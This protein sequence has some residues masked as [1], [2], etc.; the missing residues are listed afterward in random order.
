MRKVALLVIIVLVLLPNTTSFAAEIT[1]QTIDAAIQNG[2]ADD[3]TGELISSGLTTEVA[4]TR[5]LASGA[6]AQAVEQG[7]TKHNEHK[8]KHEKKH[9]NGHGNGDCVSPG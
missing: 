3:M 8:K 2:E 9:K 1:Q 5:M 7:V 6:D 4:V